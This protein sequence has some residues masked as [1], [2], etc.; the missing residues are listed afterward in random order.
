MMVARGHRA[1]KENQMTAVVI[2]NVVFAAFVVVGLLSLLGW[3]ILADARASGAR[4]GLKRG[5]L[6]VRP[7]VRAPAARSVRR[8]G[9]AH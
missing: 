3:A 7:T 1:N 2:L 8:M 9:P 5:I 4:F 6:V